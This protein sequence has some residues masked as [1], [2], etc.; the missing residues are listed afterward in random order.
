[1]HSVNLIAKAIKKLPDCSEMPQ[2]TE[3]GICCVT[4][5]ESETIPRSELFG[6]SFTNIDILKAPDSDRISVD[7]YLALSYKW[8]RMSCWLCDGI[9]FDRL[10]RIDF[11]PLILNGVNRDLWTAY[12][13]TSYKKH[14]ALNAPVNNKPF[15]VWRFENLT[16]DASDKAK[17]NDWYNILN[18]YLHVGFGRTALESLDCSPFVMQKYGVDKWIK[19]QT[20]AK[21]KYQSP[22]YQMLC[23]ILPS[24]EEIK[25]EPKK[26]VINEK[27]TKVPT[28]VQ[29][30][31]F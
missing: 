2:K 1:M 28:L 25:I 12:I 22:L 27:Q 15:G 20:W 17:V 23:Y 5:Q 29:G 6:K 10:Q 26:E 9:T 16:V 19:F 14:G 30:T 4:G 21:D 31:F 24:Q 7:A 8:E 18:K 13:T 11:R 3:F